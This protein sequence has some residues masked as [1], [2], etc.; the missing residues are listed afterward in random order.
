MF[1]EKKINVKLLVTYRHLKTEILV[2]PILT[3]LLS[4]RRCHKFD[5]KFKRGGRVEKRI[6]ISIWEFLKPGGLNFS[7]I[8][9]L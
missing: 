6:P 5:V 3:D 1:S 7:I 9:K 2:F 4:Q 8:S